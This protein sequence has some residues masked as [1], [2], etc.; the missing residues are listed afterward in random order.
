MGGSYKLN[1]P[2][3]SPLAGEFT[4][5][6]VSVSPLLQP[7]REE[8]AHELAHPAHVSQ[9]QHTLTTGFFLFVRLDSWFKNKSSHIQPGGTK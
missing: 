3:S 7:D 1:R 6:T 9:G 2:P 5:F 8:M 4:P